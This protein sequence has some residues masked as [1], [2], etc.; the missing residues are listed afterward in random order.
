M[1]SESNPNLRV[2]EL[3]NLALKALEDASDAAEALYEV[4]KDMADRDKS[5]HILN[6]EANAHAAFLDIT[7]A[8]TRIQ[9]T[10]SQIN[11]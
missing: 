7:R 11:R 6:A 3:T 8:I 10:N 5:D 1:T 4:T 2:T 9:L